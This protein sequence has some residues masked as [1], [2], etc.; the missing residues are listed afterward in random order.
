MW[1]LSWGYG[2]QAEMKQAG[3]SINASNLYWE[4]S[5]KFQLEHLHTFTEGF[6]NFLRPPLRA[7]NQLGQNHFFRLFLFVRVCVCARAQ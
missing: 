4:S 3:S 7:V 2:Q 1:I 5:I 6:C